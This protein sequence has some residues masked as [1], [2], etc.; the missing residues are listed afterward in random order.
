MTELDFNSRDLIKNHEYF[1]EFDNILTCTICLGFLVNPLECTK[2]QTTYCKDCIESWDGKCPKRCGSQLYVK[3]HRNT[4]QMLEK[5]VIKCYRC[6]K[7]LNYKQLVDHKENKCDK[8]KIKCTNPG[9]T[10][11]IQKDKLEDHL[12]NCEFGETECEECGRNT[13]KKNLK[14]IIDSNRKRINEKNTQIIK[15]FREISKLKETKENLE[16]ENESLKEEISSLKEKLNNFNTTSSVKT[17]SAK[18]AGK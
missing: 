18:K 14:K 11:E 15:Y 13:I 5:L 2:C 4:L 17:S 9:C 8:I 7:F 12:L 6:P 10:E 3:P 16:E 1:S